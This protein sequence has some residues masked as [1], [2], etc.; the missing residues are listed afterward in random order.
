MSPAGAVALARPVRVRLAAV[1]ALLSL[2]F[3]L[4][5]LFHWDAFRH[6]SVLGLFTVFERHDMHVYF[7]S[8]AWVQGQGTL[9]REVASEYLLP[10]NLLFGA[11]RFVS[12][13]VPV[14]A[15]PFDRFAWLWVSVTLP[16]YLFVLYR[17]ITRYPRP[18]PLLWLTPAALH[19]SLYRFDV[20]T[21]VAMLFAVEAIRA[22]HLRRGA[23]LLG[24]VSALKA[25]ALFLVP[26][27]TIY[28]WSRRPVRET[29]EVLVLQL[30]PFVLANLVVIL[31]AGRDGMLFP[32]R[33]QAIRGLN[34]ESGYDGIA[35][36][37]GPALPALIAR[38]RWIPPLLQAASALGA[39]AFRPRRFEDLLRAFLFALA[40]FVSFSVFYSPQFVLW[41][42]PFVAWWTWPQLSV[43]VVALSW[44]T[45]AYFP[46][47]YFRRE[48]HPGLFRGLIVAVTALRFALMAMAARPPKPPPASSAA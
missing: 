35:Y 45:F 13:F 36:L 28:V 26:A 18:A 3:S 23:L 1:F 22:D 10:A 14:L 40:G 32:F 20:Y 24:L 5:S 38:A 42:V 30:A 9:Y 2:G 19:F 37:T 33:F 11:V 17:L 29:L 15:D 6:A 41:L 43:A 21:V 4:V 39:A 47:A 8:S 27:Y 48:R 44:I 12:R 25:Y 7:L 34:G 31:F 46:I 16:L